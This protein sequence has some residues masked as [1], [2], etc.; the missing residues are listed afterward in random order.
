MDFFIYDIQAIIVTYLD[1]NFDKKILKLC[2]NN[3]INY[4]EKIWKRY[5]THYKLITKPFDNYN[6]ITESFN[7]NINKIT[8]NNKLHNIRSIDIINNISYDWDSTTPIIFWNKNKFYASGSKKVLWD[9]EDENDIKLAKRIYFG[10]LITNKQII[11]KLEEYYE[12]EIY[13]ND[14][15]FTTCISRY[16]KIYTELSKDVVDDND[17]ICMCVYPVLKNDYELE[18]YISDA[19]DG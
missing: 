18:L 16:E 17:N 1:I 6:I 2:D 12:K 8:I 11:S 5:P 14:I 9:D 3:K 7:K 13:Y 4:I 15:I 10:H 19:E